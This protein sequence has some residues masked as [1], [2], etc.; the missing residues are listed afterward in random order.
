[1]TLAVTSFAQAETMTYVDPCSIE[2]DRCVDDQ[3]AF[4]N[5]YSDR[6]VDRCLQ[7]CQELSSCRVQNGEV[8]PLT[9]TSQLVCRTKKVIKSSIL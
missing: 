6:N 4:L 5:S 8:A 9:H 3:T 2:L 7:S 1:M